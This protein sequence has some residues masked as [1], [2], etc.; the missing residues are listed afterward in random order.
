MRIHHTPY[1]SQPHGLM[2]GPF[3]FRAKLQAEGLKNIKFVQLDVTQPR[4]IQSAKEHI[5][6]E[7]GKLDV[8]VNNAGIG[9][10]D[11]DQNATT[12]DISVVRE[13]MEANFFGLIQTTTAFVP[14]LRK[15]A[16]AVILNVSSDMAS[17]EAQARPDAGLH[18]AAYNTSKAAANSYTI[19]L[20]HELRKDGINVNAVT[21]GFTTSKLNLFT[22][23]GKTLEEGALC[24]LPFALLDKEGPTGKFFDSNGKEYPW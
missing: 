4:S 23:G 18:F 9:R 3:V 16:H 21:P 15:A 17:N 6:S 22:P 20:S 1:V 8:L 24:L 11:A 14:L 12:V 2:H 10:M 13:T 7:H 19:A 5:E